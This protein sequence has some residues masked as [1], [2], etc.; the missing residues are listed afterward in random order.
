MRENHAL[1]FSEFL[2]FFIFRVKLWVRVRIVV[3]FRL[4]RKD[5]IVKLYFPVVLGQVPFEFFYHLVLTAKHVNR[6]DGQNSITVVAL[7]DL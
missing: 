3:R 4:N 6:L 5:R 7:S 2:S 1:F